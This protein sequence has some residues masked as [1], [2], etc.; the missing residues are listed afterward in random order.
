MDTEMVLEPKNSLIESAINL[1]QLEFK[2]TLLMVPGEL[3]DYFS[4]I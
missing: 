1:L 2:R 4:G 3:K